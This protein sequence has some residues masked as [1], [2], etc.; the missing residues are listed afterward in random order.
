M[1]QVAV[2]ASERRSNSMRKESLIFENIDRAL[3]SL[4]DVSWRR[5]PLSD[6]RTASPPGLKEVRPLEQIVALGRAAHTVLADYLKQTLVADDGE[7]DVLDEDVERLVWS[8]VNTSKVVALGRSAWRSVQLLPIAERRFFELPPLFMASGRDA[9]GSSEIGSEVLVINH[10]ADDLRA[11]QVT[12]ALVRS[13]S[14]VQR[15]G[16]GGD[17]DERTDH[18]CWC[19]T[20]PIH[21]H[22]GYH[23]AMVEELRLLDTWHSRR[24]A[25]LLLPRRAMP[26]PPPGVLMVEEE[27]NGFLCGTPEKVIAACADIRADPALRQKMLHAGTAN[28]AP[29]AREWITIASELLS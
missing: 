16:R 8:C 26:N 3:D 7:E 21:V 1:K 19:D 20:A 27:V 22:V 17:G 10:E 2:Y 6:R 29:L 28:V 13:G 9:K 23:D 15:T 14:R 5:H 11:K 4:E 24:F 12:D 18:G 25:I